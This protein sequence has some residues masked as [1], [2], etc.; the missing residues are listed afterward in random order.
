ME[1]VEGLNLLDAIDAWGIG[2]VPRF[3][4]QVAAALTACARSPRGVLP[5]AQFTDKLAGVRASLAALS[6]ADARPGLERVV[7]RM[8]TLNWKGIPDT[9]A[10]GDLTLENIIVRH[11]G[12]LA[13][14]DPLDGPLTSV[15]LDIA[16]LQQDTVSFWSLRPRPDASHAADSLDR[17]IMLEYIGRQFQ[18]RWAELPAEFTDRQPQLL[19]FQLLR[20]VPYCRDAAVCR[21]L[22]HR[23]NKG[24]AA[25]ESQL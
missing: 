11:D 4:D 13:F 9:A 5:A 6:D 24:A 14:I 22:I 15:S 12:T 1:F 7:E 21:F 18:S 2:I 8:Q 23:I 10:H 3:I 20:I 25:L 17:A 16:K 19:L